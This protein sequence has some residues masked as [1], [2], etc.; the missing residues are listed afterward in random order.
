[1]PGPSPM[2]VKRSNSAVDIA[3]TPT[4]DQPGFKRTRKRKI[5]PIQSMP[6]FI[7]VDYFIVLDVLF[8]SI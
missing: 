4:E 2:S 3:S 8:I 5:L 7:S 1:M 6:G